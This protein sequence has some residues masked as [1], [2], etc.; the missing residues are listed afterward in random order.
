M[1]LVSHTFPRSSLLHPHTIVVALTHSLTYNIRF[2]CLHFKHSQSKP[3][4]TVAFTTSAKSPA[5]PNLEST[6]GSQKADEQSN[7]AHYVIDH[8]I[9]RSTA[10][11]S[12]APGLTAGTTVSDCPSVENNPTAATTKMLLPA[13]LTPSKPQAAA[14]IISPPIFPSPQ[15]TVAPILSTPQQDAAPALPEPNTLPKPR[16]PVKLA[17]TLEGFKPFRPA[18]VPTPSTT[19]ATSNMPERRR[20][21]LTKA[22]TKAMRPRPLSDCLIDEG[23]VDGEMQNNGWPSDENLPELCLRAWDGDWLPAPVDWHGRNQFKRP[24]TF[25]PDIAT[26]ADRTNLHYLITNDGTSKLVVNITDRAGNT[27]TFEN[28][29]RLW[30]PTE[31]DGKSPQEF[32]QC[33]LQSSPQPIDGNDLQFPPFWQR[34]I[35]ND[36][37]DEDC[38]DFL[39]SLPRPDAELDPGDGDVAMYLKGKNLSAYAT[40]EE[41]NAKAIKAAAKKE[42]FQQKHIKSI[43]KKANRPVIALPPHPHKPAVNMYLRPAFGRD[44]AQLVHIYNHYVETYYSSAMTPITVAELEIR[45][46]EIAAA[47]LNMIVAVQKVKQTASQRTDLQSTHEKIIGFAFTEEHE[48]QHALF[49]FAADLEVYVHPEYSHKGV[50]K[51]L[52]DRMMFLADSF[53]EPRNAVEWRPMSSDL[54]LTTAGGKRLLG[55]VH[56]NVFYPNDEPV[57][58]VWMDRW[59]EN[60]NFKRCGLVEG[61][62]KLQ[63]NVNMACFVHKNFQEINPISARS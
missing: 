20:G 61:G 50:G 18:P 2:T 5:S 45:L 27:V 31:I 3:Q 54:H 60:F 26:W 7:T 8:S 36:T 30:V 51:S 40:T 62:I 34:Y 49:R 39:Q 12:T 48:G 10:A 53:Y 11:Q 16:A 52:M 9:A 58:L 63:K 44:L 24:D 56:I 33:L 46:R 29:P 57:R 1:E 25:A 32:W 28:V 15:P 6:T 35:A 14:P 38:N 13:S 4:K 37:T 42:Y 19:Q 59:L 41:M 43:K 22:E 23:T 21:W 55:T 47:N 17:T